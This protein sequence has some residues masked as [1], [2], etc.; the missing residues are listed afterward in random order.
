[1]YV[2]EKIFNSHPQ[3]TETQKEMDAY[4]FLEEN[5]VSYLRA[6]HDEAATIELCEEVEKVL[7]AKICKN[8]LLTNRQQTVFYLLL[9]KGDMVFKTKYL[10]A[11]I[12]SARLSFANAEQMEALLGV[13]PGS[14][15]VLALLKDKEKKVNLLIE[16]SVLEEEFF[17]C[18]PMVNTATV[19]IKTE[20]LI[21]KVLPAL[22]REY[23][24]VNLECPEDE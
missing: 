10:S 5:N 16:E 6:E 8:L 19:K 3:K 18:H 24:L 22:G 11:Q 2:N 9:I 21:K 17:A 20:D 15:T 23:K 12:N 4:L 13:T 1:M 7:A 14:L